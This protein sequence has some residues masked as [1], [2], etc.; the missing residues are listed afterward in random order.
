RALARRLAEESVVLLD[1]PGGLLPLA[2]GARIAVA[3]P[4]AADALAMLGCYS[5]PSHVLPG[6]PGTPAGIGIPTLLESL[7]SE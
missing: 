4:R 7:R 5:F 3:G 6:H 2:P 1:N